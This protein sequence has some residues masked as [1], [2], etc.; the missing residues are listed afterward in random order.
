MEPLI[1]PVNFGII[2]P[3]LYRSN[4]LSVNNFGYVK[5]LNLRTVLLLSPEL[6]LRTT[7]DFFDAEGITLSQLG[8]HVWSPEDEKPISDELIKEALEVVLDITRHPL[9]VMCS[10]GIH[11]TGVL[12]GCIRRLQQWSLGSII[13]EYRMFASPKERYANEQFIELFDTD[14]VNFPEQLPPWFTAQQK[15]LAEDLIGM[16]EMMALSHGAARQGEPAGAGAAT[17]NVME[18]AQFKRFYYTNGVVPLI[19]SKAQAQLPKKEKKKKK[20]K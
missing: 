11:R 7:T 13:A 15:L 8:L 1:P 18:T 5:G 20:D 17:E 12:V 14:L 16:S 19:S 2:E 9:M 4:A 6:P 10:S 3:D